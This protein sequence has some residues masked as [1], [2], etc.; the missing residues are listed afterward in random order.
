VVL[1][2]ASPFFRIWRS[3]AIDTMLSLLH[4]RLA[5]SPRP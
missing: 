1:G 2:L 5:V 4:V 3:A